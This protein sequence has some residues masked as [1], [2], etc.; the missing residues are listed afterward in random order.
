M[1]TRGR[2]ELLPRRPRFANH[3]RRLPLQQPALARKATMHGPLFLTL[4]FGTAAIF[5]VP[6]RAEV[7]TLA[8]V[9][10]QT[11][12]WTI[13]V[14][15]VKQTVTHVPDGSTWPAT[16]TARFVTWTNP[17]PVPSRIDRRTLPIFTFEPRRWAA[18]ATCQPA[19][20]G[21]V[22]WCLNS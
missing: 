1:R 11:F 10:V 12:N 21:S 17:P 9:D 14:D 8:C 18:L 16:V 4:A 7:V 2:V 5:A 19:T 15:T 22:F 3:I 6:A 20:A 13:D